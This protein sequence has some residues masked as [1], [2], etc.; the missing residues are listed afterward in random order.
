[1]YIFDVVIYGIHIAPT[2]YGLAY[3]F[4]FIICYFFMRYHFNFRESSHIDSFLTFVFFGIILGGRTGYI[5]FYDLPYFIEHPLQILKIWEWGMSFHGGFLGTVIA[6]YL[7][8][9]KYWYQFWS[10][11]DTLAVIVPIALW[12]GRIGNWINGELPWYAPYSGIFPMNI[13]WISHFPSPLFEMLLEG[14]VLF[15]L[16]L[17][18]YLYIQKRKPWLLSW[19]F[20]IG[21]SS[22][23]LI[24]EGY[25]LP[26]AHIGYL[27]STH[28]ITL[29]ILYTVPMMLYGIYLLI[30]KNKW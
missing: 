6:V 14:I 27:F 3:A 18:S 12:L 7:Y 9:R 24:A 20:L 25:R 22:A 30:R 2:W 23:R 1:M 5:V 16:M 29:G 8:C 11:I 19:I 26:D 13:G 4:G 17:L 21:Y 10:L 15:T 28:W